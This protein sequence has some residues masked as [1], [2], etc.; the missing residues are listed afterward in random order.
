MSELR[1]RMIG[2]MRLRGLPEQHVLPRGFTR[3]RH[4]GLFAPA[5]RAM[6]ATARTILEQH[7]V[8]AAPA[9]DTSTADHA[10]DDRPPWRCPYCGYGSLHWI[11]AVHRQRGPP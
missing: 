7:Q 9:T 4:Y 8:D 2:D 11:R 3:V 1:E 6:L 5:C 10:G